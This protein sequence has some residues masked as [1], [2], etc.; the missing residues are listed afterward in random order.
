M[1]NIIMVSV[2]VGVMLTVL[3]FI[4]DVMCA[5]GFDPFPNIPHEIVG[6]VYCISASICCVIGLYKL[7]FYKD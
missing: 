2:I 7:H 6:I 5:V 4:V 1:K 3:Y